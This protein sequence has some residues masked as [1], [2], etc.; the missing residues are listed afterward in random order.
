METATLPPRTPR[1]GPMRP[2]LAVASLASMVAGLVHLAAAR[3]HDGDTVLLWMFVLCAVAQLGWGAAVPAREHSRRLLLLGL[4]INGG[5]LLVWAL[6]R[7]V[8]I[9]VIDSLSEVEPVAR[10]D[11]G[12]ASFAATS[13][14]GT[15]VLLR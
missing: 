3:N 15:L 7:T 12:A 11:L 5:A 9:P 6:T 13:V 4:V 10:Q 8:G 1:V 2:A 14:G